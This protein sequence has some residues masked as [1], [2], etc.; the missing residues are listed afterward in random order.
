MKNNQYSF[1]RDISPENYINNVR[2]INTG[3]Q[4]T[5]IKNRQRV[6]IPSFIVKCH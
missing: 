5:N 4:L 2:S 6:N 1:V 3:L